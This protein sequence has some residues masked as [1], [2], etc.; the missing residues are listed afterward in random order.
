MQRKLRFLEGV[1]A[2]ASLYTGHKVAR[3]GH[4][5]I[6]SDNMGL[7]AAY[8]RQ[9]AHCPYLYSVILAIASLARSINAVVSIEHVRRCSTENALIADLLSKGKL[10][11]AWKLFPRSCQLGVL[12]LSLLKWLRNPFP[13]R[14]LG[15]AMSL[16]I[17]Q[18]DETLKY[19]S[20]SDEAVNSL[21]CLPKC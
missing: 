12:S 13:T 17:A 15:H 7:V 11:K 21:L 18:V 8:R 9:N 2:L 6:H 16:E 19:G 20:E 10:Q 3:N 14:V 5:L 1:A 4:L